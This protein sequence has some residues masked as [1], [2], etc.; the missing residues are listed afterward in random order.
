MIGLESMLKDDEKLV[1]RSQTSLAAILTIWLSIPL[2]LLLVFLSVFLPLIVRTLV[3]S[4]LRDAL[5]EKLGIET[6]TFSDAFRSL[7][8]GLPPFVNTLLI[9]AA[10]LL[11]AVWFVWACVATRNNS[12][13]ELAFSDQRVIGKTKDLFFEA[14]F[15]E[16]KNVFLERS[17]WGKLFSYGNI[18]IHA[19]HASSVT[20]R[21]LKHPDFWRQQLL[22]RS[23]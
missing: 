19:E 23:N 4:G 21:N 18:T 3:N 5:A 2:F 14:P 22:L 15:C 8:S 12:G 1:Q 13:D 7:F 10:A 9:S 16:I 11:V 20:F 17:V 6:P